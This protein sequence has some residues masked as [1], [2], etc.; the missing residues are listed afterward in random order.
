MV[1]LTLRAEGDF[2]ATYVKTN[3]IIRAAPGRWPQMT[4]ADWDTYS[5]GRPWFD[6]NAHL[7]KAGAA[8]LGVFVRAQLDALATPRRRRC[9]TAATPVR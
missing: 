1:W 5:A 3:A 4:V 2:A 9:P 8:A 7:N 6:T